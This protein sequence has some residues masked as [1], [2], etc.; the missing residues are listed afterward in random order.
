MTEISSWKGGGLNAQDRPREFLDAW[1]DKIR[2][3]TRIIQLAE[4]GEVVAENADICWAV[5][6]SIQYVLKVG[7]PVAT[8]TDV[9]SAIEALRR[10][11]MVVARQDEDPEAGQ[12]HWFAMVGVTGRGAYVI[13][14]LQE[15]CHHTAFFT[16]AHLKKLLLAIQAGTEPDRFYHV[17]TPHQ[18]AFLVYRRK[19]FNAQAVYE[20]LASA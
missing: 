15:S 6:D 2:D 8:V 16:L 18:F 20:F 3:I 9:A 13:E 10:G 11:Y 5:S 1:K 4:A 7:D 12:D 17:Q 14:Y 19:P